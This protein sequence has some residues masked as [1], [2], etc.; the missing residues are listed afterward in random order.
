MQLNVDPIDYIYWLMDHFAYPPWPSGLL[1]EGAKE[2]YCQHNSTDRQELAMG[3]E[4]DLIRLNMDYLSPDTRS[5]AEPETIVRAKK[6]EFPALFTWC[7][8]VK[9]KLGD[10]EL[11]IRPKLVPFILSP[12]SRR[13]YR[14]AFPEEIAI[15]RVMLSAETTIDGIPPFLSSDPLFPATSPRNTVESGAAP[16]G[17]AGELQERGGVGA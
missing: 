9:E 10:V 3:A 11:E 2:T 12:Q 15:L 6:H 16:T 17:E 5:M 14:Q 13:L 7:Q 4:R 8:A 1:A